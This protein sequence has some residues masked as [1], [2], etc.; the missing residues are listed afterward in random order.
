[1]LDSQRVPSFEDVWI[2]QAL[3]SNFY[4]IT[5]ILIRFSSDI[6]RDLLLHFRV[7]SIISLSIPELNTLNGN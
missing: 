3:F 7:Y 1:M 6:Y 5:Y 4:K 2:F